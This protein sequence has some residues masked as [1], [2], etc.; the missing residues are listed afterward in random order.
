[1]G[2]S[3]RSLLLAAVLV[4]HSSARATAALPA[5]QLAVH[6]MHGPFARPEDFCRELRNEGLLRCAGPVTRLGQRG[7]ERARIFEARAISLQRT[8]GASRPVEVAV[9]I[10]VKGGWFID[11]GDALTRVRKT[12]DVRIDRARATM[13]WFDG[14]GAGV[15]SVSVSRTG[16]VRR[17]IHKGDETDEQTTALEEQDRR[18]CGLTTNG[19][20]SCTDEM[21]E[22]C[23]GNLDNPWPSGRFE[24][25]LEVEQASG[26]LTVRAEGKPGTSCLIG[27]PL[28][29]GGYA[30]PFAGIPSMSERSLGMLLG[31]Y[32]SVEGYCHAIHKAPARRCAAEPGRWNRTVRTLG[33]R[34]GVRAVQLLRVRDSMVGVPVEYCRI[35]I[36]TSDG[37]YFTEGEDYCQGSF[38][39]MSA[40]E[41]EA[42]S[43]AWV[44]GTPDP[45]FVLVTRRRKQRTEYGPDDESTVDGRGRKRETGEEMERARLC[46]VPSQS[47]PRCGAEYALAC[48]DNE[49]H[50]REAHWSVNQGALTFAPNTAECRSGEKLGEPV[51]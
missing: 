16:E 29:E 32:V 1:M 20:P 21:L 27:N 43:L 12:G 19:A 48:Y 17:I 15:L 7:R 14:V 23:D 44:A 10:K 33:S 41:T 39:E 37:W 42:I 6:P 50:R 2:G 47:A 38:G 9:A 4:A 51:P 24:A 18:F 35:G 40:V 3:G 45:A 46:V 31:P 30:L 26:H 22:A 5:K 25:E 11:L 8:G 28:N 13:D 36:E 49:G 34:G